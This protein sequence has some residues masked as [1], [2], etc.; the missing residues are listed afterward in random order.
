VRRGRVVATTEPA[1]SVVHE[2][3][4]AQPVTYRRDPVKTGGA[5]GAPAVEVGA[6]PTRA[7]SQEGVDP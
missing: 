4:T 3:G 6:G 2:D 5:S 7:W 1:R